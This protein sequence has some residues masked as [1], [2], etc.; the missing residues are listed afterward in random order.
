VAGILFLPAVALLIA[1]PAMAQQAAV[2]PEAELTPGKIIPRVACASAPDQTYALYLPSYFTRDRLWPVLLALDPAAR[3]AVPVELAKDAAEKYGYIVAGSNNSRNGPFTPS[4]QAAAAVAQ[5][6]SRRF[7]VDGKRFYLTGFSG[8]ARAAVVV[9]RLCKDCAAGVFL[10]GAG[11]PS[12]PDYRPQKSDSLAVFSAIGMLDFNYSE[13]IPLQEEFGSLGMTHRLRRWDGPHNWA[14][15]EAW[16]EALEWFDLVA[17]RRGVLQR[18]DAFIAQQLAARTARARE[19]EAAGDLYA[20]WQE[21]RDIARDFAGLADPTAAA[22]RAAVLERNP[23]MQQQR[24]AERNA[25]ADERRILQAFDR[26]FARFLNLPAERLD[27]RAAV[28][29][30]V[31][32]LRRRRDREA[33][34]GAAASPVSE[35]AF[36]QVSARLFEAGDH[37]R[38]EKDYPLAILEFELW[39][40]LL[41]TQPFPHYHLARTHSLAGRKK[42]ALRALRRAVELGFNRP[43]ALHHADFAPLHADPDF[44]K[45]RSAMEKS[46]ATADERR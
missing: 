26:A 30:E 5:D 37:A 43:D 27:A 2:A 31:E 16:I 28:E 36:T 44:T 34:G 14:P 42:D 4:Y 9:A 24:D 45:L 12:D 38:R 39:A 20:A 8:G 1:S 46:K 21:C 11:F 13:V 35:R 15:P 23:Q 10:H 7:P 22:A 33:E 18:S 29:S 17:M 40:K 6:V 19:R 32:S 3:G 25:I 41:P